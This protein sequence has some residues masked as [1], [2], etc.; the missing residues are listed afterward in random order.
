MVPFMVTSTGSS[1][2][3]CRTR[4]VLVG[5]WLLGQPTPVHEAL[6]HFLVH[7]EV[8]DVQGGEVLEEVGAL[9]GRDPEVLESRFH[10]DPGPGDIG[11]AHGNAQPGMCGAPP[12]YP[13]QDVGA[14]GL[15][16][17]TVELATR[18]AHS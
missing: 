13:H 14:S 3:R 18:P 2:R 10:N 8:P 5:S 9:R 15:G 16:Q 1:N 4:P 12:A 17:L 6:P 7:G 11:P